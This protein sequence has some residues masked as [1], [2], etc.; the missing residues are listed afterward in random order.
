[1]GVGEA[2]CWLSES[3]PQEASRSVE[4]DIAVTSVKQGLIFIVLS[5]SPFIVEFL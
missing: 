4:A 2:D 1:V 5:T 3:P